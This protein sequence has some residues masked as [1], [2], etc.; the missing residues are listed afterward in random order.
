MLKKVMEQWN[1]NK[2]KLRS[3]L[4]NDVKLN[5][6][7]YIYLVEKVVSIILNNGDNDNY[8]YNIFSIKNITQIDNGDYQGTLL[9]IIPRN[10]YQPSAAEYLMTYVNYGSCSGCDTLQR[11]QGWIDEP[12]TEQQLN[13]YMAL[14]LH[15]CENMTKPYKCSW[16]K[17]YDEELNLNKDMDI[18]S[19][20]YAAA[21]KAEYEE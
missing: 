16:W 5:S 15:L 17:D 21:R 2:D 11:I 4:A 19:E 20:L 13:D 14:C 10:T 3:D 1:K 9:F 6:C 7:E 18:L 8:D 12:P